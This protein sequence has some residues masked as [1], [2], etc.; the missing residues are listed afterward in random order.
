MDK[1]PLDKN[2][3][4]EYIDLSEVFRLLNKNKKFIISFTT[5]FFLISIVVAVFT[6]NQYTSTTTLAPSQSNSSSLSSAITS[7]LGGIASLAGIDIGSGNGSSEAEVAFQIMQSWGFIEKFIS[8]NNLEVQLLA[9]NGWDLSKNALIINDNLY[10]QENNKWVNVKTNYK[11]EFPSSWSL[12]KAFKEKTKLQRNK[13]NGTI[14]ISFEYYSPFAAKEII[15]LYI[16]SI[17]DHMR[18]RKLLATQKN[19][20][21]L[22]NEI[23]KTSVTRMR[24][25]FYRLIEEQSNM[26]MLAQATPDYVFNIV[27]KPMISEEKSSPARTLIVL[28]YSLSAFLLAILIVLI[29]EKASPKI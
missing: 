21:Y 5:I 9:T 19:I 17:N 22:E 11:G 8:D 4:D 25:I 16:Q 28:A 3:D 23:Q 2:Y 26:K 24:E 10:D 13:Q 14:T 1:K 27:N 15:E 20:E 12:Y 7:E 29:R 6:P 18:E